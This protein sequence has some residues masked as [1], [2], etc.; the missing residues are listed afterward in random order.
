[1]RMP[2]A[3]GTWSAVACCLALGLLL[4]ACENAPAT[5]LVLEASDL[6]PAVGDVILV[7]ATVT[8]LGVPLEGA[9]VTWSAT[10]AD[11]L[12]LAQ[13]TSTTDASGVTRVNAQVLQAGVI[14]V[15]AVCS[16]AAGTVSLTAV[17]VSGPR[18]TLALDDATIAVGGVTTARVTA[19]R[20]GVPQPGEV[21]SLAVSNWAAAALEPVSVTTSDDGSATATVTGLAPGAVDVLAVWSGVSATASLTVVQTLLPERVLVTSGPLGEILVADNKPNSTPVPLGF[22]DPR[23]PVGTQRG[24]PLILAMSADYWSAYVVDMT[25]LRE[26][27]FTPETIGLARAS[28]RAALAARIT[29]AGDRVVW[30]R[31]QGGATQIVAAK[32]DGSDER[33]CL[34]ASLADAPTSLAL[35]PDDS[36]AAY[37]TVGGG[38]RVVPLTGGAPLEL[39]LGGSAGPLA[40]DWL[41]DADLVVAVSD[42][43][44]TRRPAL[45]RVPVNGSPGGLLFDGGG[46]LRSVPSSVAVDREGNVIF[47][48]FDPTGAQ[49]EIYRVDAPFYAARVSIVAR[50]ISDARPVLTCF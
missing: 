20:D 4:P 10:P 38:V 45:I 12:D 41:S 19:I 2:S 7:S 48:E 11:A 15:R 39:D 23:V 34:T 33:V 22:R 50:D 37:T 3:Q 43:A 46:G 13:A 49:S 47:D 44:G 17:V 16:G 26:T 32:L 36:L 14:V 9:Q 1:M 29:A 40:L 24:G 42:Y 28:A 35:S 27:P 6:S 30:L 18:L 8:R 25:T 31:L 5:V 21:V